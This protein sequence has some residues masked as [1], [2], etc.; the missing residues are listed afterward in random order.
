VLKTGRVMRQ[1]R[2]LRNQWFKNEAG[3]NGFFIIVPSHQKKQQNWR[4]GE[5]TGDKIV[6]VFRES[7]R[8]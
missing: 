3:R 8:K 4:G 1:K 6:A 5:N 2:M 7:G